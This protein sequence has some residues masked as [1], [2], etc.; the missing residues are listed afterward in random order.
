MNHQRF[1]YPFGP[2]QR[3]ALEQYQSLPLLRT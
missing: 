1:V 3:Q 2:E